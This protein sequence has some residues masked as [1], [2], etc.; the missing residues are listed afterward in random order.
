MC[1]LG[2]KRDYVAPGRT[3]FCFSS[4]SLKNPQGEPFCSCLELPQTAVLM[5]NPH[6]VWY[7]GAAAGLG[8]EKPEPAMAHCHS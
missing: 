4:S 5:R 3:T 7:E 2:A 8:G 1:V 6:R